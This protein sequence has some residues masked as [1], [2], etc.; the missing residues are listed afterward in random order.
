MGKYTQYIEVLVSYESAG[1][2]GE[3]DATEEGLRSLIESTKTF[4]VERIGGKTKAG[5]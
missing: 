2:M 3:Y 4:K 5:A 1:G